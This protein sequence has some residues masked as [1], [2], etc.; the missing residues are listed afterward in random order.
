[1]KPVQLI[2]SLLIASCA[3]AQSPVTTSPG[4]PK[5]F[6]SMRFANAGHSHGISVD[7]IKGLDG[8]RMLTAQKFFDTSSK[9]NEKVAVCI[10]VDSTGNV[11]KAS[12]QSQGSTTSRDEYVKKALERAYRMKFS[13]T[14][15]V[16][17]GTVI[18]NF[19]ILG[20]F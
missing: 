8:V 11:I 18:F 1:M 15:S 19:R 13:P 2:A 17:K 20:N 7:T 10:T 14:N 3:A 12:Y 16:S 6:D 4:L 5:A 9:E